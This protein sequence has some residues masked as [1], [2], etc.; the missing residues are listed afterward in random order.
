MT[1]ELQKTEADNCDAQSG[2]SPAPLLGDGQWSQTEAIE[3]C[4]KVEAICPKYGCH[5]ALT[6]GLLYKQGKR[7]DCDLLFYRIRQV[8]EIDLDGLWAA[9]AVIGLNQTS[10]F[11]WCYKATYQGK[12]LDCFMP[13]EQGGEYNPDE[14]REAALDGRANAA[15][16][17]EPLNQHFG[18]SPNNRI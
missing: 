15:M 16:N 4:V 13:E 12:K 1:P 9:L 11:G 2:L 7:K 8:P 14:V 18:E 6:G 17:R 10:G 5:V 3:L